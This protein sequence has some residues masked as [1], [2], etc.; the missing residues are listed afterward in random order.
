MSAD[1]GTSRTVRTGR[2]GDWAMEEIGKRIVSGQL[3]PG[4]QLPTEAT[5]CGELGMSRTTVREAVKRLHG[6]GLLDGGP[7]TGMRVLP[8]AR[9]NQLDRDVLSWRAESGLDAAL[10]DQ[11]YAVRGCM[12]PE[13]CRI[14]A[15]HAQQAERLHI[16]ALVGDIAAEGGDL[17]SHVA[18]DVAFHL[19]I[20]AATGNPF[21]VT[22]GEAIR[23]ALELAFRQ[24]QQRQRMSAAELALHGDVAR[25]IARGRPNS[26]VRA[27]KRL[28]LV[29]RRSLNG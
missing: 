26:A 19:A 13:A 5:L 15:E 7:R 24:S 10:A 3:Q 1:K 28:L 17:A 18:A 27:M 9:W 23:T 8:T 12:E 2:L 22:L 29:S 11:L 6:K 20:F 21:F 14:A 4:E 25:A 16:L